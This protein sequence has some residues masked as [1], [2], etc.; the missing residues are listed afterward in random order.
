[1]NYNDNRQHFWAHRTL[2]VRLLILFVT[3]ERPAVYAQLRSDLIEVEQPRGM[4]CASLQAP[5]VVLE[6]PSRSQSP[7]AITRLAA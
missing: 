1:M 7:A 3:Y 4:V 2:A 5:A 6:W